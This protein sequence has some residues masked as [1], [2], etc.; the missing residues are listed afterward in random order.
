MVCLGVLAALALGAWALESSILLPSSVLARYQELRT[1]L[2]AW[3]VAHISAAA[4]PI[5]RTLARV[6][7]SPLLYLGLASVL[8][9]ERLAPA[10][11]EQPPI[12]RGLVHDGLAW[13][14]LDAPLK[15]LL[16]FG[17][18]GLMYGVL[19]AYAPWLRID[20]R[21]TSS[22]PAWTLVAAAVVATDLLTWAQH[23]LSHKVR[24]LWYFH[25]IHHS[26]RQLNLFTQARYHAVDVATLVPF[27]YLQLYVLNL[28]FELAVWIV[29]LTQWYARIT[30]ANLRTNL[31]PLKYALVTPQS[32]RIHHS[33]ERRHVDKNFATLFAVW[34]RLFG[35]QWPDHD[36]YPA[37][38]VAGEEFP[39]DETIGRGGVLSNYFAQLIYPFRKILKSRRAGKHAERVP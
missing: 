35:T 6:L 9:A 10:D 26:Q 17:S 1:A 24:L 38:G 32:H 27:V 15:G 25:S 3:A 36:E 21:F 29:L 8:V 30:H 2:D 11:P 14:L 28:D 19:D 12:S 16:F 4:L 7:L 39:W 33:C 5:V 34:D 13:F 20:P 37:T 18:L 22:I 23:Y 31:G